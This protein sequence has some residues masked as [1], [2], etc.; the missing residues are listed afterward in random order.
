MHL[1]P[2]RFSQR[3]RRTSVILQRMSPQTRTTRWQLGSLA[4]LAVL[5]FVIQR[6][7]SPGLI[8][9][10]YP[11]L[12]LLGIP[13]W[14]LFQRWGQTSGATGWLRFVLMTSLLIALTGPEINIG[15]RGIDVI[16]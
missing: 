9:F 5:V 10:Q 8:R 6:W 16:V 4:A 14:M 7:V 13:L 2:L 3:H 11:E 15:G 12:F 1:V